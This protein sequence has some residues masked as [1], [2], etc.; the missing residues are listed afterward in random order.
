MKKKLFIISLIIIVIS[1][2]LIIIFS[3]NKKNTFID[4][5]ILFAVT[6]DGQNVSEFPDRGEYNV[7][8]DCDN[9]RGRWLAKDWKLVLEDISGKVSCDINFTTSPK[10][11]RDIVLDEATTI[12]ET[13]GTRYQGA[14]PDNYIWFNEELWRIVGAIPGKKH[15]DSESQLLV[16]II[17]ND[18][19][20]L[21]SYDTYISNSTAKWGNNTLYTLLNKYYYGKGNATSVNNSRDYKSIC[22]ANIVNHSISDDV[23]IKTN[24]DYTNIGIDPNDYYGKMIINALWNIGTNSVN[25]NTCGSSEF[26]GYSKEVKDTINGY[27]GILTYSD[28]MLAG[29]WLDKGRTMTSSANSNYN[30]CYAYNGELSDVEDSS[31]GSNVYPSVYLDQSAYVVS[32]NGSE[33][34]PYQI[35]M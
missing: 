35:A 1:N 31:K 34:N 33:A 11:L 28:Y 12:D 18:S 3:S 23:Y 19:I 8:I 25:I 29:S 27:V 30:I 26:Y 2:F 7:Q 24:C 21:L 6:L 4:N 5:G 16:K 14:N 10:T 20:G 32:G 15:G 22:Y 13:V 17:R 9:A